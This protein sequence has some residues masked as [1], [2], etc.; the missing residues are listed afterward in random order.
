M[1]KR[2]P[3]TLMEAAR[4]AIKDSDLTLYR[5]AKDS[6]VSYAALHRFVSGKRGLSL[7]GFDTLCRFLGLQL[8]K[9]ERE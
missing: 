2:K 6:G 1:A 7:E 4:K 9:T 8:V 5:I 3:T